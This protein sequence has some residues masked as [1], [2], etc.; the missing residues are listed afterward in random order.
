MNEKLKVK[1]EPIYRD[2]DSNALIFINKLEIEQYEAKKQKK[3][4]KDNALRNE[5]NTIKENVNE[6]KQ[7]MEAILN[8]IKN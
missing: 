2:M 5:I 7:M 3:Q 1:N 4:E 8:K 6:L